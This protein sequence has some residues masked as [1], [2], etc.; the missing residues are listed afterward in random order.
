MILL[1]MCILLTQ[2][3]KAKMILQVQGGGWKIISEKKNNNL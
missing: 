1:K 2:Q 3:N